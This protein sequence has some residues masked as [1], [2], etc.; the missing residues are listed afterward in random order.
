MKTVL[1]DTFRLLAFLLLISTCS[2][3]ETA[4]DLPEEFAAR[5]ATGRGVGDEAVH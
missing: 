5:A 2:L 4:A 3:A 1:R